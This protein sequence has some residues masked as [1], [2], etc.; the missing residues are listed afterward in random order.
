MKFLISI[1]SLIAV[2]LS[3]FAQEWAVVNTSSAFLRAEPDYESALESQA[4]M[5]TVLEIKDSERYWRQV[6]AP[7]YDNV[8]VNEGALAIMSE[9]EKNAYIA[10]P[11]Y[12]CVADYTHIYK[13][14]AVRNS[15]GDFILGD[16]IMQGGGSRDGWVSVKTA[17]GEEG[18]VTRESV[19]DYDTWVKN[20]KIN[21]HNVWRTAYDFLGV[22]YM[23][24]G[25]TV[26]H[27][28][29][30][31]LTKYVYMLNGVLLPRN[32]SQQI[33]CGKVIPYD[34]EEMLPGDLVF[35]GTKNTDGSIRSVTHVAMYVGGG[36]I[37]H[38][39]QIV[40][41]NSLVKGADF[42]H[43]DR[44]PIAVRRMI[45]EQGLE[46]GVARVAD[47]PWYFKK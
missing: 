18:W 43:Y 33:K 15:I 3:C 42:P 21:R 24:G 40:K 16:I 35:F 32:A 26:K 28:D 36:L 7:D 38:S 19:E 23:W 11:K 8:W 25:N 2:S 37:I 27:F 1:S 12:I 31:G 4:L 47:K 44:V 10:A 17:S 41:V 22:P 9:A 39:S 13:Y 30:S 46:K 20:R 45:G 5:G 6:E 34:F 29:C 14:P